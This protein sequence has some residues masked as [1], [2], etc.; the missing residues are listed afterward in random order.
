M[1][2]QARKLEFIQEF[3]KVQSEEVL[4]KLEQIL[5]KSENSEFKP[6]SINQFNAEIDESIKNSREGNVITAQEL[7]EEIKEWS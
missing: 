1:D 6:M 3:L 5:S 2:I 7:K 4:S